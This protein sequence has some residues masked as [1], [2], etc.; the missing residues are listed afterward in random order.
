[1]KVSDIEVSYVDLAW[2][3][4]FI[5]GE[6]CITCTSSG[7]V[8]K[9]SHT[10]L[11]SL[12]F[13][14]KMFGGSVKERS[15]KNKKAWVWYVCGDTAKEC[16]KTIRPYLREK[17]PQADVAINILLIRTGRGIKPNYEVAKY[18]EKLLKELAELK[19]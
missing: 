14:Q 12:Q 1:M 3:A 13:L 2:C 18:R 8:V 4:G 11:P 10:H 9:V 6:G 5:D 19:K 16:L 15:G 7:V 17:L